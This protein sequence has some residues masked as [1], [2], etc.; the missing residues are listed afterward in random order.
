MVLELN[1]SQP[2]KFTVLKL[3]HKT[4]QTK[5]EKSALMKFH[6]QFDL[7]FSGYNY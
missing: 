4:K 5:G 3:G 6:A 7:S 2:G 1:Q